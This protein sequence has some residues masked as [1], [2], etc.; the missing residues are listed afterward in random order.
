M[1]AMSKMNMDKDTDL[2]DN[3]LKKPRGRVLPKPKQIHNKQV[4][5]KDNFPTVFR[6]I[7]HG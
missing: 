1:N 7:K 5:T 3:K 6:R 4:I 2:V